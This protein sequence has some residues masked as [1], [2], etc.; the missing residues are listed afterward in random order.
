MPKRKPDSQPGLF[1][2][3]GPATIGFRLDPDDGRAL[4]KR[5]ET[6]KASVHELARHYV[7]L[8]LHEKGDRSDIQAAILALHKEMLE[9]RKDMAVSTESLL[10]SAGKVEDDAAREWV[11][12]NLKIE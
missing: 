3:R 12:E 2:D 10:T 8:A 1:D 7:I 4:T 11:R 6:L 5:A 9:M